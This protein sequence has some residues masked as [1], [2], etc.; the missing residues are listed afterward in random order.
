MRSCKTRLI[1]ISRM[2]QGR[3]VSGRTLRT[4]TSC[5]SRCARPGLTRKDTLRDADTI[6]VWTG[7]E[8]DDRMSELDTG[9]VWIPVQGHRSDARGSANR[10]PSSPRSED[11][12]LQL[13]QHPTSPEPRPTQT[14][15]RSACGQQTPRY[16][17]NTSR[18]PLQLQG[19]LRSTSRLW[20]SSHR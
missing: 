10:Q 14:V 2:N 13:L 20:T 12:V 7:P 11:Q 9:Q 18:A 6:G 15:W 4:I 19:A 5:Q 1:N 17:L 8:G 3:I 16:S